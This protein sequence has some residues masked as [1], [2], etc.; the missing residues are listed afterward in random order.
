MNKYTVETIRSKAEYITGRNFWYAGELRFADGPSGLRVQKGGGDSLGLKDSLPATSFPAHSALANSFNRSLAYGVGKRIGEE[1]AASG[2]DILLAPAINIK[3]S[4]Y[5]GRNFEYFSEDNYLTGELGSA[6]VDGVQSTGV[7]ACVKHFAVNNRETARGVSDSVVSDRCLYELYL[8]A[9]E[10]IVEKSSPAAVMTS[11]NKLNGVYCNESAELIGGLLR[12]RWGFDGI[13]VSDWGGTYDRVASVKAGADVEMPACPLSTEVLVHAFEKGEISGEEIE[14]CEARL[15]RASARPK[16]EA[17]PY[18]AEEHSRFAYEAACECAVLLKN[19]GALP[20]REGARVAVFGEAAK[21]A[22]IQGGGSS[23]VHQGGDLGVLKYLKRNFLVTGFVG[24]YKKLSSKARRLAAEADAVIVCLAAYKGDTEGEDKRTLSLPEEQLKLVSSLKNRGKKVICLL[25][26]GGAIDVSWD[27]DVNALLYLGLSGEGAPEA[28]ADILSGKVNPSGKLAET[29]F[30]SPEE[31]PSTAYFNVNDYYTVYSECCAV[32]YRYY[33]SAGIPAKYPFGFGLSYTEFSFSEPI[34]NLKGVTLTV[35]NVGK[36]D[37]AEVVQI[38]VAFPSAANVIS[39]VLAG[40]E[41]VFLKSGESRQVTLPFDEKTFTVYDPS[42]GERTVV[43]GSYTVYVAKSSQNFLSAVRLDIE[44][45]S[46]GVAADVPPERQPTMP[47]IKR[48][49]K[50]RVIAE[51]TT[52]FGELVN[53]R[54]LLV[55]LFVRATLFFKRNSPMQIGT[56]RH[57][58][59]KTVAQFAAFDSL[60]TEG[61]VNILNGRYFKGLRLFLKG[62]NASKRK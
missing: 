60:R 12:G 33:L 6:Y 48:T 43:G 62:G 54:A 34:V 57:A 17:K 47:E 46:E 3:R 55:R 25:S 27:V 8:S 59:V 5:N 16:P 45:P 38:Y 53:S 44:G 42:S 7:G 56:L 2:V 15:K 35:A 18:N 50:G 52:P 39:P 23:H 4:P 1:A 29:F 30:N 21:D 14:A 11:Y 20:L 61:F 58:P 9:F 28:A 51:L 40:F 26:G 24:G 22:P 31:L 32:G 36:R 41:K 49:A 10:K 37:G 19:D 13:V